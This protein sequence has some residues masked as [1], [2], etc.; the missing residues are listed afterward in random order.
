MV[1]RSPPIL[2]GEYHVMSGSIPQVN[3]EVEKRAGNK[4]SLLIK[5]DI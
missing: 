4:V 2:L 3:I 1:G 5:L